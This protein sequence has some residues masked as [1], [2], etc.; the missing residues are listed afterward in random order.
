MSQIVA[1]PGYEPIVEVGFNKYIGPVYKRSSA[2]PGAEK[3][4]WIGLKPHMLNGGNMAHGG[5]LMSVADIVMG[6][7]VK[8]ATGGLPSSTVSLNCDFVAGAKADDVV[9]ATATVTR[10]TRS[11]VFMS[12][13]LTA[14]GRAVLTATGIWKIIGAP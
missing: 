11:L 10:K 3:R 5:F 7:S 13:E 9:E 1:P 12:G 2:E 4:F 8:E 14:G 6:Y